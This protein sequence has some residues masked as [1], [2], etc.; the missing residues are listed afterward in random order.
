MVNQNIVEQD[1]EES[2]VEQG[3]EISDEIVSET[4]DKLSISQENSATVTQEPYSP[5][6]LEY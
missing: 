5:V 4:P 2:I 1:I 3:R 6:K